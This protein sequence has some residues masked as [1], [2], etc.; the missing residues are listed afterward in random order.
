MAKLVGDVEFEKSKDIVKALL[1]SGGV[2]PMA[3]I[4][5]EQHT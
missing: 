1:R 4:P 2:G 5:Y 3:I